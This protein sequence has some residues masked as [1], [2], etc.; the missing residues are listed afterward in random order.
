MVCPP[1]TTVMAQRRLES[2]A[3]RSRSRVRATFSLFTAA[4]TSPFWKPRFCASEPPS[5]STTTTPSSDSL[6]RSSSASAGE[7]LATFMPMNGERERITISSRGNS[8]AVSSAIFSV[9]SLP[10]RT[11]PICAVPPSGLVAKR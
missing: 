3:M 8:G 4:I 9:T 2:L 7:I 1:R 10:P 5:T 11:M 6:M